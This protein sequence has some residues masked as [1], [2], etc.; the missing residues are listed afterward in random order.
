[1]SQTTKVRTQAEEGET[2]TKENRPSQNKQKIESQKKAEFTNDN[3]RVTTD[4]PARSP[5]FFPYTTRH[6]PQNPKRPNPNEKRQ[7]K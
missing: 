3:R 1:M 2:M 7:Q 5:C 6:E 4:T